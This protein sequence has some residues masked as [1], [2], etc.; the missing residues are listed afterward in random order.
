MP[1]AVKQK[2]GNGAIHVFM[3]TSIRVEGKKTPRQQRKYLGVLDGDELLLGKSVGELTAA[4]VQALSAKGIAWNGKRMASRRAAT[5]KVAREAVSEQ[6]LSAGKALE[7]GRPLLL[8]EVAN[9]LGLTR[10]LETAFGKQDANLALI[11][12][13][14]EECTGDALCRLDEWSDDTCFADQKGATSPSGITRLCQRLGTEAEERASFFRE[15]FKANKFPRSLI[16]DTTSIS[17]YSERLSILEWGHNRDLEKMP[18][19]NLNMV[20]ARETGL[21]LY[22]RE[23][24]GSVPDIVTITTT[25]DIISNLGLKHYSFA[26]DRGFFSDENLWYFHDNGLGFTIGVPLEL[27]GTALRLLDRCR[28]RLHAFNSTIIFGDTTLNHTSAEYVF[29]RKNHDTK[30]KESFSAMAHIYLNRIRQAEEERQFQELLNGIM[31]DFSRVDFNDKEEAEQWLERRTGKTKATVFSLIGTAKLKGAPPSRFVISKDGGFR[32]S[33]REAEYARAVR[34]FGIFM[35][36]NSSNE[37]DGEMTLKDNRSRDLQEKVFDILKNTTGND[38]LRVSNDDTLKGRLFLAFMAV[39]LHKAVEKCLRSANMLK[40]TSVNKALDLA[41]KFNVICF[42]K[43]K[44]LPLEVP[45][46]SRVIFEIIAPGL[47][48]QHGIDP[49]DAATIARKAMAVQDA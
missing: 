38:R 36:L 37:A 7:Y 13:I 26:L 32:L 40:T 12:A 10:A 6:D 42:P 5:A 15:W 25:A 22:Y 45:K 48:K 24:F 16:S 39:I 34:N 1:F 29:T 41:R 23:L 11:A 33:V 3:A 35:I 20:Y 47:L 21:P 14:Y 46:K 8:T 28:T 19:L 43:G 49:G 9:R 30:K 44:R 27:H 4:E 18:Q 17:S 2:M 31:K